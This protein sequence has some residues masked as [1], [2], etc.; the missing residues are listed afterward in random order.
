MV[1]GINSK[2][3]ETW[4]GGINCKTFETGKIFVALHS[5]PC[6]KFST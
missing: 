6:E 2:I 4:A 5:T 1:R 3:S